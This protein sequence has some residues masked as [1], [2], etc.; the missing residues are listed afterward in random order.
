MKREAEA[1]LRS[2]YNM[3]SARDDIFQKID[4]S[5][6]DQIGSVLDFAQGHHDL[7][8]TLQGRVNAAMARLEEGI[9]TPATPPPLHV[10]GEAPDYD[11]AESFI[12]QLAQ[13]RQTSVNGQYPQ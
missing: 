13:V 11:E 7:F 8:R 2:L 1:L 12:N 4:Q 3:R 9:N 6:E 10:Q 5:L